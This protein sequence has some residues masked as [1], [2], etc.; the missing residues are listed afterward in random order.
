MDTILS[1]PTIVVKELS[2][3]RGKL[4]QV[5]K[6][7]VDGSVCQGN[8]LLP[9]WKAL[10]ASNK[11]PTPPTPRASAYNAD[12]GSSA[13]EN[14]QQLCVCVFLCE[15]LHLF[16]GKVSHCGFKKKW[17]RKGSSFEV[18]PQLPVC[19]SSCSATEMMQQYWYSQHLILS[20]I[21]IAEMSL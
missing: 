20:V 1:G 10:P 18:N 13:P 11:P 16:Q 17:D 21:L 3:E 2:W 19:P 5:N 14:T 6:H 15:H 8:N 7:L 4:M 12:S 9:T